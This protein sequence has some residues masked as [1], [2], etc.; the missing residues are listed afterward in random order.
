[1]DEQVELS[2]PYGFALLENLVVRQ[3]EGDTGGFGMR[4][5]EREYG[6]GVRKGGREPTKT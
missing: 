4:S 6:G 1:M 3:R 2:S 5:W